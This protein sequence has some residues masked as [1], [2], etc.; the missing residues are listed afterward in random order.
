MWKTH[1]SSGWSRGTPPLARAG[2]TS[3]QGWAPV[4]A[5]SLARVK[6]D[7]SPAEERRDSS[8]RRRLTHHVGA[9]RGGILCADRSA[10][11][12]R[13]PVDF[14]EPNEETRPMTTDD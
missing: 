1:T 9:S 7:R 2:S 12:P 13:I 5:E 11:P 14:D 10:R 3:R 4:E 6:A 8:R